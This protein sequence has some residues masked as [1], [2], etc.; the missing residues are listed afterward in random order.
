MLSKL[1]TLSVAV[2]V[3]VGLATPAH[4]AD[5]AH[6]SVLHAVPGAVVDVYAN[7][8]ALLTDFEPGTLT[9]PVALPAGDYDLKVVA[10]GDGPDGDALMQADGVTVPGGANITVVAHLDA[11][12][13]PTLTP[14]VNDTSPIAAGVGGASTTCR[15][16]PPRSTSPTTGPSTRSWAP[17]GS[18]CWSTSGPPGA[19]HVA[20]SRPRSSAPPS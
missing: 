12:G 14:Y 1:V 10:A 18:R 5:D 17:R 15:R 9:D 2:L 13:T 3:A 16:W 8:D 11:D 7:G 4:A 6:V 20:W 19:G